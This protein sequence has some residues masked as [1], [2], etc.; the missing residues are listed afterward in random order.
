M[1]STLLVVV[2]IFRF[3]LLEIV[4]GPHSQVMRTIIRALH[5]NIDYVTYIKILGKKIVKSFQPNS[6]T[7]VDRGKL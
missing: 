3:W 1:M 4:M 7:K 2:P 6:K 5:L